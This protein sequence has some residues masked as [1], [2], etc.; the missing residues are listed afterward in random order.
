MRSAIQRARGALYPPV[1]PDLHALGQQLQ[2]NPLLAASLD[3]GDNL[4]A[5]TVETP[6]TRSVVFMSRR[7]QRALARTSR[8]FCD[9]TFASRP[10]EPQARQVLQFSKVVN[11]AIIPLGQVLMTGKS[12]A[13]YTAVLHHVRQ[14]V[15]Q[16]NPLVIMT[17]FEVGLQ[18]AWKTV[19]PNAQVIGCYWHFCRAVLKKARELGLVPFMN[20]HRQLRSL[21]RAMCALPLLPQALMG[22]GLNTLIQEATRRGY[23]QFLNP[24]FNYM[25]DTWMTNPLFSTMSVYDQPHRT[26]N[27]SES[28]NRMLRSKTGAHRPG[29]WHF[30]TAVR[31]LEQSATLT[32]IAAHRGHHV[33]RPKKV[34]AVNN[35]LRIRNYIT[36]LLV[37]NEISI[38]RFLHLASTRVMNVFEQFIV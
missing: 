20:Q 24:Y 4:Y 9:A 29:L 38:N 34:S 14:L 13:E 32:L 7:M 28:C 2:A 36:L 23:V 33:A 35:D 37:D 11:R 30:L 26:N 12:E 3:G 1:P 16:F 10:N 27:V 19:F 25:I 31:R 5:G 17:D 18:N 15:P 21:I 22:R 6:A 8:V